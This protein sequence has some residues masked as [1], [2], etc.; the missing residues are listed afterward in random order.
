LDRAFKASGSG[1]YS[2]LGAQRGSGLRRRITSVL[3]DGGLHRRRR[4]G[5]VGR[6]EGCA[7]EPATSRLSFYAIC[8]AKKQQRRRLG[9]RG[10]RARAR[11]LPKRPGPDGRAQ[12]RALAPSPIARWGEPGQDPRRAPAQGTARCSGA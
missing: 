2:A 11:S 3:V 8:E 1:R 5:G 6:I 4:S 9:A 12:A 10:G 7:H